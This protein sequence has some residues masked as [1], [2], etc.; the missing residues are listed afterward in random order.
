M[1]S[2]IFPLDARGSRSEP[3]SSSFSAALLSLV[4]RSGRGIGFLLVLFALFSSHVAA[5]V[6]SRPRILGI[7]HVEILVSDPKAAKKFYSAVGPVVGE[8]SNCKS[9]DAYIWL[10]LRTEQSVLLWDGNASTLPKPYTP[11]SYLLKGVGFETENV[12]R[13]ADFLRANGISCERAYPVDGDPYL[14]AVDPDGHEVRFIQLVFSPM[15]GRQ[16][17]TSE[18]KPIRLIH[19]G[20]IVRDREKM[21]HFYKDILGFRPYWHGGRTDDRDDWISLQVP[22]GSDWVEFMLNVPNDADK[23]QLGVANHIALGVTDIQATKEQL[24]KNGVTLTEEP[25]IGRG[26]K[27]QLN[28]YDPDGTR[29]EFMEF[30]PV[31]KPCCSEYT[32]PHPKP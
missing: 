11:K 9:S 2:Q 32:A 5:Q 24:I 7:R 19:A 21:E 20:F 15:N 17:G 31:Q 8:C 27:W 12:E 22:D 16:A 29:I 14:I 23:R 10:Q 28:V 3:W 30:T 26:G 1:A 6:P 25:K 18:A 4:C 13:M